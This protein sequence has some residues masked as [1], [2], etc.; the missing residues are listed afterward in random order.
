MGTDPSCL[1]EAVSVQG[2]E[3]EQKAA[4]SRETLHTLCRRGMNAWIEAGRGCG[5]AQD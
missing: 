5:P 1:P 3:L 2:W 4:L